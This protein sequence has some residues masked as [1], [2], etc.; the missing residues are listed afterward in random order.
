M[1]MNWKMFRR[2][3]SIMDDPEASQDIFTDD[4]YPFCRKTFIPIDLEPD[5]VI[6]TGTPCGSNHWERIYH[7]ESKK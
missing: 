6:V 7:E 2:E 5:A 1:I 4:M 3:K